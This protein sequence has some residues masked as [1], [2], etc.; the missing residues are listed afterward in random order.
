MPILRRQNSAVLPAEAVHHGVP[1]LQLWHWSYGG[2]ISG[3]VYGRAGFTDGE[4]MTTS[5][6]RNSSAHHD[7]QGSH[8]IVHK[9]AT[10]V[11]AVEGCVIATHSGTK[12]RLGTPRTTAMTTLE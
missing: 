9:D 11:I 4:L 10:R 7:E 8:E 1:V 2:T 5:T 12:Y 6:V 3:H